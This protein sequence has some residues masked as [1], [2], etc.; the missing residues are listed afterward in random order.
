MSEKD[1][2]WAPLDLSTCGNNPLLFGHV[3]I[4]QRRHDLLGDLRAARG[5]RRGDGS[6]RW[7]SCRPISYLGCLRNL[8]AD[9]PCTREDTDARSREG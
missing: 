9:F 7:P 5:D 1:P 3:P 6:N 4:C 8:R 2:S